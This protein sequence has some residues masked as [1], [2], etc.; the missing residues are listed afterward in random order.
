MEALQIFSY[1]ETPVTFKNE[2]GVV[3]ISATEMAQQFGK[4][5]KDY[6]RTKSAQELIDAISGRTKCLPTEIVQVINGGQNYGTWMQE[7]IALDFAQWLSIDFKL[8]CNDRIKELLRTGV[9]TINN[10]DEV[11][12]QSMLIL[13][14]RLEVSRQEKQRLQCQNDLQKRE[15]AQIAPKAEYYDT[16]LQSAETYVITR[17]AQELGVSAVA[18]N[19]KLQDMKVQRKVDGQWMLYNQYVGNGYT[20]AHTTTYTKTDGTTGTNT[21]TVW[22]EKGREFIH[23]LFKSN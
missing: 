5:P 16:V 6:L 15:I 13:Q 14:N 17:I 2:N 20:K 11:I 19:K 18:M 8:W 1:N 7:D 3:F 12:A 9:T 10:D 22:T 4:M 23:G 21:Q